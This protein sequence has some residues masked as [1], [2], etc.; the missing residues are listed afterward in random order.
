MPASTRFGNCTR[1]PTSAPSI[2]ALEAM[3]PKMIASTMPTNYPRLAAT[4]H[5]RS[6]AQPKK[7]C[8]L[9]GDE[10]CSAAVIT[11]LSRLGIVEDLIWCRATLTTIQQGRRHREEQHGDRTAG[12]EKRGV[13]VGHLST[14]HRDRGDRDDDGQPG[15]AVERDA[16]AVLFGEHPRTARGIPLEPTRK[17]DRATP[18]DQDQYHEC[19]QGDRLCGKRTGIDRHARGDEEDRNEQ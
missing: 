6:C 9:T 2:K 3:A 10:Q 15:R 16:Q 17:E 12:D 19:E 18:H 7:G 1:A 8:L 5:C 14:S 13:L 4:T 11:R